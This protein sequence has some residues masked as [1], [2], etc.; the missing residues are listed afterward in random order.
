MIKNKVR[1][2]PKQFCTQNTKINNNNSNKNSTLV[3]KI[4]QLVNK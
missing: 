2:N 3:K 4:F 1:S